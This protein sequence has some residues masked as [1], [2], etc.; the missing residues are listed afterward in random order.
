MQ[1]RMVAEAPS[2]DAAQAIVGMLGTSSTGPPNVEVT[3]TV[4]TMT[5]P[6]YVAGSGR[7]D[8]DPAFRRL[9]ARG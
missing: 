3:G 2:A 5:T 8:D 6:T 9:T 1:V 7:L 4:V